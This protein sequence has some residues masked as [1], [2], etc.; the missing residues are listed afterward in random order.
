MKWE[1]DSFGSFKEYNRYIDQKGFD[2]LLYLS[3]TGQEFVRFLQ[4]YGCTDI[5]MSVICHAFIEINK[6]RDV[7]RLNYLRFFISL[8]L[9]ES[10]VKLLR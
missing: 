9:C 3:H 6:K 10:R 8:R 7:F 5:H 2:C 1:N 4:Q